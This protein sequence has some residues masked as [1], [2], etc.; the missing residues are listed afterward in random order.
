MKWKHLQARFVIACCKSISAGAALFAVGCSAQVAAPPSEN[1][2]PSLSIRLS[3]RLSDEVSEALANVANGQY[4][5][6]SLLE[7]SSRVSVGD[8]DR[9]AFS[10]YPKPKGAYESTKLPPKFPDDLVKARVWEDERTGFGALFRE[11]RVLFAMHT[12]N[13]VGREDVDAEV[14]AYRGEFG[15]NGLSTVEGNN[16]SYWFWSSPKIRL[17]ICHCKSATGDSNLTVSVGLNAIMD[18]LR[19]SAEDASKDMA[20]AGEILGRAPTQK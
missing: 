20:F 3:P 12:T 8:S 19:M 4:Q 14:A 15:T 10:V 2:A 13:A 6:Y 7:G 9:S 1:Q 16:A 18:S 17:M 11:G 5:V